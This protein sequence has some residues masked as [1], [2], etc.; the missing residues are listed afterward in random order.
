MKR[1]SYSKGQFINGIEFIQDCDPHVSPSRKTRMALFKC[2]CGAEFKSI[3]RS[4]M[5]GNTKSCGCYG[6]E[7]RRKRFT[8]HGLRGSKAYSVWSGIKTRCYNRNRDDYKYYGGRGI[9]LSD[10]FFDFMAFYRYVSR[11]DGFNK[12]ERRKLTIDRIDVNKNYERGNL[13]WATR[14]QQVQNR[15]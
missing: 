9:S 8:K 7:S 12:I 6:A 14:Q 11:L 4:V 3:I 13:R 5:S 1:V 15:R 2:R 10:E